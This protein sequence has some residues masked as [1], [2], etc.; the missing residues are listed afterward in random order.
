M[1]LF[2]KRVIQKMHDFQA[3]AAPRED[4]EDRW[5]FS[6]FLIKLCLMT[7]SVFFIYYGAVYVSALY[8]GYIMHKN[9]MDQSEAYRLFF[10]NLECSPLKCADT[11]RIQ[12]LE[13]L[14][15]FCME[16]PSECEDVGKLFSGSDPCDE[17]PRSVGCGG[18][19]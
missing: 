12:R 16:H 14:V 17:V 7:F 19:G 1:S 10:D 4:D 13:E 6:F 18:A 5:M 8:D 15:F 3:A 11:V 2:S 9:N